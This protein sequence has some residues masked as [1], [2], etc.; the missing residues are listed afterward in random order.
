MRGPTSPTGSNIGAVPLLRNPEQAIRDMAPLI[1]LRTAVV[2]VQIGLCDR[3]RALR[4]R[5]R[6]PAA[7]CAEDDCVQPAYRHTTGG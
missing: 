1:P 5:R 4:R 6:E 3:C 2:I 7:M